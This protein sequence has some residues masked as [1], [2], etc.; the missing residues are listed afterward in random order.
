MRGEGI[1]LPHIEGFAVCNA[2]QRKHVFDM[3]PIIMMTG[4][5]NKENVE[6]AS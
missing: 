1:L 2:I 4:L 3:M 6:S 5:T